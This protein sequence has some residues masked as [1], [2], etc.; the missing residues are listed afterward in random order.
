MHPSP[1]PR[2]DFQ[3]Q[4]ERKDAQGSEHSTDMSLAP[5]CVNAELWPSVPVSPFHNVYYQTHC[6]LVQSAR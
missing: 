3:K 1:H 4:C 2:G 5:K 6:R